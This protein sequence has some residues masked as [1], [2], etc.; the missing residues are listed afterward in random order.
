[1][2][3]GTLHYCSAKE[4]EDYLENYVDHF[5]LRPRFHLRSPVS[6]IVREDDS[7][8]WRIDFDGQ[9]SKYFDKVVMAT[10]PHVQPCMPRLKNADVFSGRIIHSRAFK[11]YAPLCHYFCNPYSLTM[12]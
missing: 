11:T 7:E 10:G 8:K 3:P 6:A 1:M 12:T 5:G 2:L 4:V 9:P